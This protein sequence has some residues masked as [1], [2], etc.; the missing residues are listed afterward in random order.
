MHKHPLLNMYMEKSK[1]EGDE[2]ADLSSETRRN[3]LKH[4]AGLQNKHCQALL[5]ANP[6]IQSV[7]YAGQHIIIPNLPDPSTIPYSIVVYIGAKKLQLYRLG[8]L[9]RTYPI[10]V[11]KILTTTPTG[12]FYIVNRQPKPGGPFGAYWLSLS[13]LHYGIHGTNDPSSIGKAVSKGCIRMHNQDVT[14]LA[15]TVP[16]GTKVTIIR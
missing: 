7:I 3:H 10:A 8:R 2:T 6:S 15:A 4:C 9:I 11:G 1:K 13:K 12:E 14:E 5:Q 16:N